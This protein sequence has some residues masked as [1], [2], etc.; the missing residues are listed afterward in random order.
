MEYDIFRAS[1][2]DIGSVETVCSQK[3]NLRNL[4]SAW[5]DNLKQ[6]KAM[7]RLEYPS[8]LIYICEDYIAQ[9][10]IL[11]S[12]KNM[13]RLRAQCLSDLSSQT[14]V[15]LYIANLERIHSGICESHPS[16]YGDDADHPISSTDEDSIIFTDFA[17]VAGIAVK[18]NISIDED[19]NII[20]NIIQV[21]PFDNGADDTD[22]DSNDDYT[23]H[24]YRI[25]VGSRP[26]IFH[27]VG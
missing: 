19:D 1:S 7:Q 23:T 17:D 24:T 18:E 9:G 12:L 4:L 20:N 13:D 3:R 8:L 14:G 10:L 25:T 15:D 26:K 27:A 22:Y 21:G 11:T 6:D 2:K 16:H 5:H